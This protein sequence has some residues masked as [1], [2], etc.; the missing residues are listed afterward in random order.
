MAIE[1]YQDVYTTAEYEQRVKDI[2][3]YLKD[4][5]NNGFVDTL[6]NKV[7]D[8]IKSLRTKEKH[9]FE[10][11]RIHE[12]DPKKRLKILNQRIE[13]YRKA[14]FNLS[15]TGLNEEVIA[16]LKEEN[17]ARYTFFKQKTYELVEKEILP[18]VSE[19]LTTDEAINQFIG[20]YLDYIKNALGEENKRRYWSEKGISKSDLGKIAFSSL[21][22]EQ[23]KRWEAIIE[24][25]FEVNYKNNQLNVVFNWQTI[26]KNKTPTQA[27]EDEAKGKLNVTRINNQ[28]IN[29]IKNI[30]SDD[31]ALIED[32]IRNKILSKNKYAFFVGENINDIIGILGEIQGVYYLAKLLGA[33][34]TNQMNNVEWR[35]GTMTGANNAK[36]HQDIVLDQFGIQVK[37]SIEEDFHEIDFANASL[38]TVLNKTS[39][40]TDVKNLIMNFYGTRNFNVPY[41]FSNESGT[42]I[43]AAS[44]EAAI[45]SSV[46]PDY[47]A[48]Y[49]KLESLNNDIEQLLSL[50]ASAFLYMDV[51]KVGQQVD[52][53]SLYLI[54]GSAFI[55]ASLILT[56]IL[57]GLDN[58]QRSI[59]FS[60]KDSDKVN[61]KNIVSAM[62]ERKRIKD[63]S[64]IVL[65]NMILQSSFDFSMIKKEDLFF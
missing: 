5:L 40:S 8:E 3:I 21:T 9:I 2:D 28:V 15:G 39:L 45:E 50:C 59:K 53:N 38:E 35:G 62:N 6:K 4:L 13:D 20:V 34:N 43:V 29:F 41:D 7:Q 27:R 46:K 33:T 60:L 11:L 1:R 17:A 25:K 22:P 47:I 56:N 57:E 37:N 64:E 61:S 26:T 51:A 44:P 65:Q 63:Y 18:Q 58:I 14:V 16:I 19:N 49:Y 55:T 32:I 23:R 12:D 31:K 52:A 36:P 54:G 24:E 42:Y 10:I 30:V 48:S